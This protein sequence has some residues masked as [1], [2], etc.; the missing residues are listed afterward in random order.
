MPF[1][2]MTRRQA[3]A[4]LEAYR[5]RLPRLVESLRGRVERRGGPVAS[6]LDLSPG[7]L[8][9][10]WEW[11]R[12]EPAPDDD[13]PPPPWVE[14]DRDPRPSWSSALLRDADEL[15]AYAGEAARLATGVAWTGARAATST[16]TSRS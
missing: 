15:A 7:S 3:E 8:D 5:E 12:R 10:L 9:L 1:D 16:R 13:P 4:Y 2:E 6:E 11:Y 14:H